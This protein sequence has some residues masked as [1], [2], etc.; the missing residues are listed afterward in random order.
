MDPLRAD[1]SRPETLQLY[2][3]ASNSP[4]VWFD[5][6]GEESLVSVMAVSFMMSTLANAHASSGGTAL[7]QGIPITRP[8]FP[9]K[10]QLAGLIY[11]ES[12]SPAWNGRQ[13]EDSYEKQAIAMT[14]IARVFWHKFCVR[15]SEGYNLSD[16]TVIGTIRRGY[17]PNDPANPK[18]R[19]FEAY[20]NAAWNSIMEPNDLMK[21]QDFLNRYPDDKLKRE[22]LLLSIDAAMNAPEAGSEPWGIGLLGDTIP[23]GFNMAS[24]SPP[25]KGVTERIGAL[26]VTTFYG[27]KGGDACRGPR[28]RH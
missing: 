9:D 12:G 22:H 21:T 13:P 18:K 11:A 1:S 6:T 17:N 7:Q 23:M 5:P 24:D 15:G 3:Y 10:Q 14:V 20:R 27:F 25:I 8:S 28:N 2:A 19:Q 4:T 16:G 26:G